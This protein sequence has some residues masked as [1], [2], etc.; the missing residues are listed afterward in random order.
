MLH[1]IKNEMNIKISE[2]IS[3]Q[4]F[5]FRDRGIEEFL[6]ELYKSTRID[7]M[8]LTG[9]NNE[10]IYLFL[11]HQFK[12]QN[13]DYYSNYKDALFFIIT[14]NKINCGRLYIDYREQEI[15]I[16][17]ISL[18]PE[19]RN[20]KIGSKIINLLIDDSKNL[21]KHLTLHVEQNNRAKDFYSRLGFKEISVNGIHIF[22]QY[23]FP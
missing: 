21:K 4:K 22:M 7:E 20:R 3:L 1:S 9:W 17:D 10:Q 6:F 23:D 18:L 15:R 12:M 8:N 11:N 16:I 19:F 2:D 5:D 14:F 13:H